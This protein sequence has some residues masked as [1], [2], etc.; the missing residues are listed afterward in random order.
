M[1]ITQECSTAEKGDKKLINTWLAFMGKEVI[2]IIDIMIIMIIIIIIIM[3]IMMVIGTASP[4][5]SS[6]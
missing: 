4:G 1:I 6:S 3:I 5:Q 2:I